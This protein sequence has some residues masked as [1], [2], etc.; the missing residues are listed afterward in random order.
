MEKVS[1]ELK[2]FELWQVMTTLEFAIE[3]CRPSI[4]RDSISA[5]HAKVRQEWEDIPHEIRHDVLAVASEHL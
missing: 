3:N 5:L 4:V 1:L 2:P